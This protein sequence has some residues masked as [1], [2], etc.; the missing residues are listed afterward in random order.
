MN[1]WQN[2]SECEKRVY[3]WLVLAEKDISHETLLNIFESVFD[4]N[5]LKSKTVVNGKPVEEDNYFFSTLNTGVE[6]NTICSNE[7]IET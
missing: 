5:P 2:F 6:S 7:V 3:E 4:L 1:Y